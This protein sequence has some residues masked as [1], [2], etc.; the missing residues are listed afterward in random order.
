MYCISVTICKTFSLCFF[1]ID[2]H[3]LYSRKLILLTQLLETGCVIELVHSCAWM[4]RLFYSPCFQT[5]LWDSDFGPTASL[6]ES[7]K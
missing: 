5:T 1:Y 7:I 3:L 2:A 4:A 6:G